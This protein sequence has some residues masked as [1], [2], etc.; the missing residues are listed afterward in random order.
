MKAVVIYK[1]DSE[2]ARAVIDWLRDF[3]RQSGKDIQTLEPET[4]EG[5]DF[6]RVY[7]I[8]EYPTIVAMDDDSKP[9]QVW[10]GLPLPL[11]NEVSYYVD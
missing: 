10:R 4:R 6:C 1:D 2:H 11:I 8:V 7:D 3:R 5:I 9:L